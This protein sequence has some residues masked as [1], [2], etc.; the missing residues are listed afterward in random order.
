MCLYCLIQNIC[1]IRYTIL[2]QNIRAIPV[3]T[4]TIKTTEMKGYFYV[5]HLRNTY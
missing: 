2:I 1:A 3:Y 5:A 4:R